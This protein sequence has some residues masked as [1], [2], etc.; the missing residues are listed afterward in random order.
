VL[1]VLVPWTGLGSPFWDEGRV[2]PSNSIRVLMYGPPFPVG[3]LETG[4]W[5][6]PSCGSG[7][8]G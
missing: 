7:S 6:L 2:E 1:G 4:N 8:P 5:F 3:A